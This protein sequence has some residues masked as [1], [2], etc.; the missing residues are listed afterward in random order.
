MRY[1]LDT[2][3]LL[4]AAG[5]PDRLST[6]ARLIIESDDHELM[7]S[8]ASIWEVAIKSGLGRADFVVDPRALHSG[9]LKAGYEELPVLGLHAAVVTELPPHH[10]DP[11]D[12]LL[13]AQT[14]V[15][16]VTLVTSDPLVARYDGSII[17]V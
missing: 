13:V 8:S 15:E 5:D 2:H 10:K 14:S 16:A 4:W 6:P 12:R 11:F 17:R 7:F 3:L 1:L 9:L